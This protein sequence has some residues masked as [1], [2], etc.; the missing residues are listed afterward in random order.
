[1]EVIVSDE[2]TG[3]KTKLLEE[4]KMMLLLFVYLALLLGTFL[5]YR[6]LLLDE[7]QI[8]YFHYGYNVVEALVLAKIIVLGRSLGVGE[9]FTDRPLIVPTLYK[10]VC[11]SIFVLAFTILEHIIVGLWHGKNVPA[12]VAEIFGQGLW[13]ILV[14]VLVL[15]V[16]LVPLFAVWETGRLIGEGKLFEL[17]FKRKSA[18]KVDTSVTPTLGPRN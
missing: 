9:R 17:F 12:V 8:G 15:F 2:T 6:R 3:I 11:F 18:G 1:M 10:T 4:T 14:R 16:A 13:E 7:Y 5:L